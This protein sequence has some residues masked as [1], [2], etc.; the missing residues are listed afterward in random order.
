V[1]PEVLPPEAAPKEVPL[2]EESLRKLKNVA[3][4]GYALQA[5]AFF[6]GGIPAVVAVVLAYVKRDDARGTWLE[7]HLRWQIRTFWIALLGGIV[8]VV[9]FIILIG[10]L[11]LCVTAVW[12]I[13]R[14]VKGWLALNDGKPLPT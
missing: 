9:T 11:I 7:S 6:L 10:W 5:L 4:A 3:L 12:V 8:G 2:G 1:N 14:I 13:Y